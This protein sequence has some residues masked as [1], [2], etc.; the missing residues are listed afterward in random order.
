V[1]DNVI[2]GTTHVE[3]SCEPEEIPLTIATDGAVRNQSRTHQATG[4]IHSGWGYVTTDGGYGIGWCHHRNAVFGHAIID[5]EMRAIWNAIKP[6]LPHRRIVLLTDSQATY[7]WIVRWKNGSHITGTERW[8]LDIR[9]AARLSNLVHAYGHNLTLIN[10][11]GHSGDPLNDTADNLAAL[12]RAWAA[13][14]LQPTARNRT[15]YIEGLNFYDAQALDF[16][17][18]GLAKWRAAAEVAESAGRAGG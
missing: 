2:E 16:A 9:M 1:A 18:K 5:A 3:P 4:L 10:I 6:R 12:G 8:I 11:P 15:S 7:E 14:A 13:W 17:A